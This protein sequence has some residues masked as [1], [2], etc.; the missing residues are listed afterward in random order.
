M[1]NEKFFEEKLSLT[2]KQASDYLIAFRRIYWLLRDNHYL[3]YPRKRYPD[4]DDIT[5]QIVKTLRAVESELQSF[6]LLKEILAPHIKLNKAI[7]EDLAKQVLS[8]RNLFIW[9]AEAYD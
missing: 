4:Y 7:I 1:Y 6:H 8:V 5:F 2:A 9:P 3:K